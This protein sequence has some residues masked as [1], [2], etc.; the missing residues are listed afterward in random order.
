MKIKQVLTVERIWL[1]EGGL[2]ETMLLG[3]RAVIALLVSASGAGGAND[4]H[5]TALA[6]VLEG[7]HLEILMGEKAPTSRE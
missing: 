1:L 2:N 3:E 5:A 4:N 6:T 7:R